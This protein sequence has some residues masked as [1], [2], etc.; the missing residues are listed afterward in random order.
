MNDLN[1]NQSNSDFSVMVPLNNIQIELFS[2]YNYMKDEE[3]IGHRV[4]SCK[5]SRLL[6][7]SFFWNDT[8][9]ELKPTF[10]S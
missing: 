8:N 5:H 3:G 4:A 6:L 7:L 10:F 1:I 2:E 9:N